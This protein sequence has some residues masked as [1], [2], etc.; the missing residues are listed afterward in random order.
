MGRK[1]PSFRK[2]SCVRVSAYKQSVPTKG[3]RRCLLIYR[4]PRASTTDPPL[5][6]SMGSTPS[7]TFA[8]LAKCCSSFAELK[9]KLRNST[10][11]QTC[12]QREW[13]KLSIDDQAVMRLTC[14]SD[15][16][17]TSQPHEKDSYLAQML[18]ELESSKEHRLTLKGAQLARILKWAILIVCK[19]EHPCDIYCRRAALS[20]F[21]PRSLTS[22]AQRVLKDADLSFKRKRD[23]KKPASGEEAEGQPKARRTRGRAP[24]ENDVI[25]YSDGSEDDDDYH[26]T[27]DEEEE[28]EEDSEEEVDEKLEEQLRKIGCTDQCVAG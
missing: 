20:E 26:Q 23:P 17:I 2:A 21:D 8:D 5:R 24:S 1:P 10:L 13:K 3:A 12:D 7:E 11:V 6:A 14:S 22:I 18:H 15:W 25:K 9:E 16:K 4:H 19:S 28:E 27:E